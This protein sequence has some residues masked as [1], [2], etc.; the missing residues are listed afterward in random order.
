M[1]LTGASLQLTLA[2]VSV[3]SP[4]LFA[5]WLRR[6]PRTTW[7]RST[8]QLAVVLLCQLLAVTTLFV[9]VN[10]QYGFYTSW[11]D[12]AGRSGSSA[13]IKTNGLST[14]GQGRVQTLS[15]PGS[16]GTNGQ[17]QVLVWLPQQYD[18]PQFRGTHFPVVMVLPGQPSTPEAMFRHYDFGAVASAAIT[19]GRVTPFIAVFPPLMTNPP[20]DTECTNVPRGPQAETWLTSDV[21]RATQNDLRTRHAPWSIL[22]WSTGGFCAAK[23]LLRHPQQYQSA[24]S[25]GGYYDVLTDKTTGNLFHSRTAVVDQNSPRWL[26]QHGGMH[27]HH[28]LVVTGRQ[29]TESYPPTARFLALTYKDPGVASLIFPT[30]GHNYH[31]YRGYLGDILGW[32]N[33]YGLQTP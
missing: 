3:M 13:T 31:N 7:R 10:N 14:P 9:W 32:L 5:L 17:H 1:S 18:L 20:R 8:A 24:A 2:I 11:S 27:Q 6:R 22:G 25:L 28:L 19:S 26:Y 30:G 33:G 12:L 16:P 23:L 29:D 15:V 21:Y 4:V